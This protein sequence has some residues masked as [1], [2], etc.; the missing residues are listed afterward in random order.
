[1]AP[2][3]S[4]TGTVLPRRFD[5]LESEAEESEGRGLRRQPDS[6]VFEARRLDGS[7]GIC[8]AMNEA[9][10][11]FDEARLIEALKTCPDRSAANISSYILEHVDGFT[12]GANQHDDMTIVVVRL[13]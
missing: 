2:T 1:M 3:W 13:L 4:D 11:E 10:E 8:E 6:P 9:D 7:D 5:L 12:A